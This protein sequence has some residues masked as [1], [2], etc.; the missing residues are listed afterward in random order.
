M[1]NT[2]D[3]SVRSLAIVLAWKDPAWISLLESEGLAWELLDTSNLTRYPPEV[4]VIPRQTPAKIYR[5]CSDLVSMGTTAIAEILPPDS[6]ASVSRV[7]FSFPYHREDYAGLENN[8]IPGAVSVSCICSNE[9]KWYHLPFSLVNFWCAGDTGRKCLMVDPARKIVVFER[10][11]QIV[12]KNLRRLILDV[13]HQAFFERHLPLVHK[14]YWPGHSRS[15]F[16]FRGDLDGGPAE[17][18]RCYLDTVRPFA[19]SVTLFVCTS[20]YRDN[21]AIIK[22]L[23][24]AGIEVQ[25]HTHC[26]Y[27]FPEGRTNNRNLEMAERF[28]SA[29]GTKTSGLV[30]PAYFWHPSLHTI[31]AKRGYQYSCCFGL[32]HDHLPYYPVVNGKINPVLEVPFHCLGDF[33]PRFHIELDSP[34]TRKFFSELMAKKYAAGEPMNLYGHPDMVGRL[35]SSPKLVRFLYEQAMSYPDIW[36]G[37]LSRLASWWNRRKEFV[38]QPFYD[39]KR[40]CVIC[41][42]PDGQVLREDV[43]AVSIHM[44]GG[45][46]CLADF[47]ACSGSGLAIDQ[48][49][50]GS[51]LRLPQ[52][53]DVGEVIYSPENPSFR[54]KLWYYKKNWNRRIQKYRELY[55]DGTAKS[56]Y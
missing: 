34:V 37:Q 42:F 3:K 52:P 8:Q 18:L 49:K 33:F 56:Q 9:G 15:I 19:G 5:I 21:P 32:G 16:C 20:L 7:S 29:F 2:S 51:A 12:K 46:W 14:W 50:A 45:T 36:T 22:S 43:P 28:L 27:V 26:H 55:F 40:Q 11:A 25:S 1:I 6:S 4:M 24:E 47:H 23:V 38:F 41:R 31:L 13:L 48:L 10:L 44:P 30:A 35:G 39:P 54:E 53:T 17:N